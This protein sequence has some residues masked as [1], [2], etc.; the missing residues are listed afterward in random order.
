MGISALPTDIFLLLLDFLPRVSRL[1]LALASTRLL[2]ATPRQLAKIKPAQFILDAAFLGFPS[3]LTW[4]DSF[5][6]SF[7]RPPSLPTRTDFLRAAFLN[8]MPAQ[9]RWKIFEWV[10]MR[11]SKSVHF[12]LG[13]LLKASL[14]RQSLDFEFAQLLLQKG[15]IW[16]RSALAAA[17]K[18]GK[19]SNEDYINFLDEVLASPPSDYEDS[20]TVVLGAIQLGRLDLLKHLLT[21]EEFRTVLISPEG[22][23]YMDTRVVY[24]AGASRNVVMLEWVVTHMPGR[25]PFSTPARLVSISLY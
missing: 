4:A 22:K 12:D 15:A 2:A 14:K 7:G 11:Q 17:L 8:P 21:H 6:E 18:A 24:A 16:T 9:T 19:Y 10:Q 25:T 3:L 20:E 23:L 5:F 13:T 1:T